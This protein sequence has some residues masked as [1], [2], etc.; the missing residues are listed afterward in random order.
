[1]PALAAG[2][3]PCPG[4]PRSSPKPFHALIPTDGSPI[5]VALAGHAALLLG[6]LPLEVEQLV[7]LSWA[8]ARPTR[9]FMEGRRLEKAL[10]PSMCLNTLH[11]RQ[12]D[13]RQ[14]H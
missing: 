6:L 2:T 12:A 11:K 7:L 5:K 13:G 3:P 9:V 4:H 8:A 1:M 10:A 14:A